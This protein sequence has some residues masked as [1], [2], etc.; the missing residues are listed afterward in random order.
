MRSHSSSNSDENEFQKILRSIYI[1]LKDHLSLINRDTGFLNIFSSGKTSAD[2]AKVYEAHRNLLDKEIIPEFR[3]AFQPA[4]E[5]DQ[6]VY[7]RYWNDP[8]SEFDNL[9]Q[10][11]NPP[12][13]WSCLHQFYTSYLSLNEFIDS[14]YSDNFRYPSPDLLNFFTIHRDDI[15]ML[16]LGPN[17]ENHEEKEQFHIPDELLN[18]INE[19]AQ[20]PKEKLD[21]LKDENKNLKRASINSNSIIQTLLSAIFT[22]HGKKIK[23]RPDR[24]KELSV[25]LG[26]IFDSYK[27]GSFRQKPTPQIIDNFLRDIHNTLNQFSS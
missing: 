13:P 24:Q 22:L 11:K 14:H 5:E 25:Q 12:K 6:N 3:K 23:L 7:N 2:F 17:T 9:V 18:E 8:E 16:D 10:I 15:A 19:L 27:Q 1:F 20:D 26:K 4:N 21:K